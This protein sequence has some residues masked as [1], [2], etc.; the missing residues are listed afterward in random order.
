MCHDNEVLGTWRGWS[1]PERE[2]L[3]DEEGA[4]ANISAHDSQHLSAR[5]SCCQIR[6]VFCDTYILLL[7]VRAKGV[8]HT[9]A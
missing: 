5:P 7:P 4:S 2:H 9:I 8:Q 3:D 1:A 6:S